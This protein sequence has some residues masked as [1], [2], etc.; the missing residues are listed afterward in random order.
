MSVRF[1]TKNASAGD[2]VIYTTAFDIQ[3]NQ[4]ANK[5][6]RVTNDYDNGRAGAEVRCRIPSLT[7]DSYESQITVQTRATVTGMFY[8]TGYV[9]NMAEGICE[10]I[11]KPV[12][13]ELVLDLQPHLDVSAPAWEDAYA[14]TRIW[15]REKNT[16]NSNRITFSVEPTAGLS[17]RNG[18]QGGPYEDRMVYQYG[19]TGQEQS[20][21]LDVK[22]QG[23]AGGTYEYPVR[24]TAELT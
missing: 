7:S 17:F 16:T 8:T 11:F 4:P 9:N 6:I 3:N 19:V 22:I 10:W 24:V 12:T 1:F 21:L 5:L 15:I 14:Q 23:R 13:Q 18:D 20:V 2:R